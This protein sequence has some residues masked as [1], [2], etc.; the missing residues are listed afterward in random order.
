MQFNG[1]LFT[2]IYIWVIYPKPSPRLGTNVTNRNSF[3]EFFKDKDHLYVLIQHTDLCLL[4]SFKFTQQNKPSLWDRNEFIPYSLH[5][6]FDWCV[7]YWSPVLC[8]IEQYIGLLRSHLSAGN[9]PDHEWLSLFFKSCHHLSG[10][11]QHLPKKLTPPTIIMPNHWQSDEECQTALFSCC[12]LCPDYFF[13]GIWSAFWRFCSA[14][15]RSSVFVAPSFISPLSLPIVF[16][17]FVHGR[18]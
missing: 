12:L 11:W 13:P 18:Q 3:K 8:L 5:S 4:E 16:C 6:R 7:F 1:N 10:G 14:P 9:G 2:F 15:P 17:G